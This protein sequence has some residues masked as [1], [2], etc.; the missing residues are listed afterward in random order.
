MTI[1]SSLSQRTTALFTQLFKQRNKPNL[2]V[3]FE[4]SFY[5]PSTLSQDSLSDQPTHCIFSSYTSVY[6]YCCHSRKLPS[7]FFFFCYCVLFYFIFLVV[8]LLHFL[9]FFFFNMSLVGKIR[10]ITHIGQVT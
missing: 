10:L 9:L 8:S 5:P 1:Q 4:S 6:F 2:N 7:F 3:L